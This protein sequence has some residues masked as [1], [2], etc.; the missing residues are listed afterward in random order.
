MIRTTQSDFSIHEVGVAA[1]ELA[2]GERFEPQQERHQQREQR[3]FH[4][5]IFLTPGGGVRSK[6]SGWRG[7][8]LS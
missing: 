1:G 4:G 7:K 5:R 3:E 6:R 8:R 2:Q